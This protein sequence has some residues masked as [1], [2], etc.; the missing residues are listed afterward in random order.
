MS[1]IP[2][3]VENPGPER[4]YNVYLHLD[5]GVWMF[6]GG[7]HHFGTARWA[8]EDYWDANSH[9]IFRDDDVLGLEIRGA[10]NMIV[11]KRGR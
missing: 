6:A 4:D 5:S 7:F 8:A 11:F 9:G 10:D 1:K 3:N 2:F